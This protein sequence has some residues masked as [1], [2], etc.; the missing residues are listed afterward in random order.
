M[1]RRM[2]LAVMAAAMLCFPAG[3]ESPAS[4]DTQASSLSD[5]RGGSATMTLAL[6]R[7]VP[8][9]IFTLDDPA[10]LVID[11]RGLDATG[12]QEADLA[13]GTEAVSDLRAGVF[14]PGW[15]RVVADLTA[16]MLP[17]ETGMAISANG[18]ATLKLVLEPA[19]PADFAAASGVP[20]TALWARA[21]DTPGT[22]PADDD[23]FTVVIDPG[24]GG[25]DPG[26]ERDGISEKTLMLRLAVELRDALE[27]TGLARAVLT[28]QGDTFVSLQTRVALAH[29]AGADAFLSLHADALTDGG[30]RGATVYTL[31]EDA[32]DKATALLAARHNRADILAGADLT[33][34]DDAVT[35]VLLDLA[36]R[37]TVPRTTALAR[38]L[39]KGMTDAGGPMNRHPLRKAGFSVLKSA[40]I[41][42][43][44]VEVGFL[45]SQRDLDNLRRPEWRT[46][47]VGGLVSGL[48]AWHMQDEARRSLVRQ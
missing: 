43:V 48:L 11:F 25:I 24:H 5:T 4:V 19:A 10:R 8:F 29:K 22:L 17:A 23:M 47:M 46:Q 42:S 15:S 27:A 32:S 33:G 45:S 39:V 44:L 1:I 14:Q 18:T 37:E 7:G 40:D 34:T 2:T 38:A 36:R 6:S 41:P 35:G 13:E 3:A 16:P 28:R 12:L 30:A 20:E 9:R 31:S 26:A 21:P